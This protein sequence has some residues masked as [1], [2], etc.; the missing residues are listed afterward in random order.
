M[1]RRPNTWKGEPPDAATLHWMI[2]LGETE[3]SLAEYYE[4]GVGLVRER[5][6]Q[7]GLTVEQ[8]DEYWRKVMAGKR[9]R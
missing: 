2:A 6:E 1:S 9:D 8:R 4:V 7:L 3:R 5:L